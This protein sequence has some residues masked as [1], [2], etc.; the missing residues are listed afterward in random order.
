[1]EAVKKN[2]LLLILPRKYW[3]IVAA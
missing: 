3:L 1:L 2:F